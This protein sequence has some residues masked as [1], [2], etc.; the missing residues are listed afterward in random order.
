MTTTFGG[1]LTGDYVFINPVT[2]TTTIPITTTY[3]YTYYT[4]N[5]YTG[6]Y[7]TGIT[8]SGY[9]GYIGV[10]APKTPS[11]T[12]TANPIS[13]RFKKGQRWMFKTETYQVLAEVIDTDQR[14]ELKIVNSN[15]IETGYQ[16]GN[17]ISISNVLDF[18]LSG[19]QY[20]IGQDRPND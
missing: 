4:P 15:Y 2:T 8:I 7:T 6:S 18:E 19:W 3:P 20:L 13:P 9:D 16:E 12:T 14:I 1:D 10:S 11:S 5:T 17:I